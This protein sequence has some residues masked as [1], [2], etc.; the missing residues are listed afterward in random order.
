MPILFFP[1][2]VPKLKSNPPKLPLGKLTCSAEVH[3]EWILWYWIVIGDV[4]GGLTEGFKACK[5]QVMG[6]VYEL[7]D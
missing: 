2:Q 3:T 5:R 4:C 7:K 6:I 1:Q